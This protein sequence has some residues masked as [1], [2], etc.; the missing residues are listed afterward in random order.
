MTLK[1]KALLNYIMKDFILLQLYE[2]SSQFYI[3]YFRKNKPWSITNKE[4]F[5][6]PQESLGFHLRCFHLKYNLEMKPNLEEHDIIHVLTN[7]GVSVIE[8][9]ALQY[10]LLGNGKKSVYQFLALSAGT[11]FYPTHLKTFIKY[12]KRGQTAYRF[13]DLK[14]EKMLLQPVEKIQLTFNIQ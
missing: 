5:L 13:H 3:K 8:E 14:F 10:Y 2:L 9:I 1:F 7:T 4:L 12:Y 11:L 6:Y